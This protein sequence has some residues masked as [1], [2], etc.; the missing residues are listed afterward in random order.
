MNDTGARPQR[1]KREPGLDVTEEDL[2]VSTGKSRLK[3]VRKALGQWLEVT[4]PRFFAWM[5][6]VVW[7]WGGDWRGLRPFLMRTSAHVAVI[8]VACVALALSSV[9][10]PSLVTRPLP[11]APEIFAQQTTPEAPAALATTLIR[12]GQPFQAS[13][14]SPLTRRTDPHTIIPERPRLEIITYTVQLGDT[15]QAIAARFGLDPTTIMWANPAV[16]DAPDLL[17]IG[18]EVIILPIDGVYHTVKEGDTLESIAEKYKVSVEAITSC[19][20]NS[21]EPPDFPIEPGMHLIVPGGE[22]PW[23]PRVVTSYTGPIPEGARGTGLFQWPALGVITQGYWYGHRAI[24]LGVPVGTAVRAA[25]GGF[26]SF[27]GW[28]DVGYGY[29][30]VV[31]HANGF[32]TYYAHLSNFYVV[33]GQA[34]ERGQVIAAT[35][36]TG[37]STGPHLHF[38]IRYYGVPQ[39][40]RAYLP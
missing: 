8:A 34:V 19:E 30:V 35:G 15:V 40:P 21:L 2:S 23:V 1:E 32:A 5:A 24:D 37:W 6:V 25:D 9:R 20:Y 36:N 22:K 18:Q 10:W 11:S 38:E 27:A 3:K 29:L 16:E 7:R 39:N 17:R 26:V 4:L 14:W 12:N 31:D 13:S 28:T 33:A